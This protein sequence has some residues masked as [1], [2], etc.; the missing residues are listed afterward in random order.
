MRTEL[1]QRFYFEAAHT[2]RRQVDAAPSRRVHGHTYVAEL[3]LC[4]EP[5]LTTGMLHDLGEVRRRIETVR[6]Q[7]D[8]HLLDE[9]PG[10]GPATLE[11][12][13]AWLWRAFEPH[14]GEQLAAI[15]VRREASGDACR[16]SC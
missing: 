11:N 2:L 6:Q 13:C 12:L 9:V 16:L 4:G 7:L 1:R 15:E 10:L 5:D 14:Y 3:T 8:H